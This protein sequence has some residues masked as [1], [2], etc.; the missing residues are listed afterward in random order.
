MPHH[1]VKIHELIRVECQIC[2]TICTAET[3]RAHWKHFSPPPNDI[4]FNSMQQGD[5]EIM[6]EKI[7]SNS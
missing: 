5:E 6:N 4:S 3:F 2:Q 7:I 1:M